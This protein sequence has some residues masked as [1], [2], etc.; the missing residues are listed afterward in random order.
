MRDTAGDIKVNGEEEEFIVDGVS[1]GGMV[2]IF[3]CSLSC[4]NGRFLWV[5]GREWTDIYIFMNSEVSNDGLVYFF[6][7]SMLLL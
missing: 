2:D 3:V 7:L 1:L 5:F 6:M 4:I